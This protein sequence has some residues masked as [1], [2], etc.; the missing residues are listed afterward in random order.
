MRALHF[1]F[2]ETVCT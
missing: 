1:I 2:S